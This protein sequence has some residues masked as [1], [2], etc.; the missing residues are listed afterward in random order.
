MIFG[1][2]TVQ[3]RQKTACWA[4]ITRI[5]LCC[6]GFLLSLPSQVRSADFSNAGLLFDEFDLT[7]TLGQRTEALGPFFYSEQK[8]TQRSWGVPPL[9]THTQD[10]A[11]E[12]EEFDLL[13]PLVTYD[14]FG[15]Q[16]RWPVFQLLSVGSGPTQH[17]DTRRRLTLFPFYFQQRSSDPSENYTTILPF[18]GHIKNRLFRD[19]ISF[20]MFPLYVQTRKADVVTDNYLYPLFHL[21]HGEDLRGWQLWPLAGREHKGITTQT[22]GFNDVQ[23]IGGH[24]KFF[25]LWPLFFEQKAGIGTAN[26][27]WMQGSIPAYNLLRS[28]QRDSTTVLWPFFSRID[29]REKQY[30]EWEV[31][32]PFIIIARGQGKTTTR[33]FPLFG[34]AHSAYLESDFYLWPVY[35]FNRVHAAPADRTRTRICFFLYSDITEKNTET[36]GAQHRTDFWPL[37]TYRRDFN[38]NSRLQILAPLEPYLPNN[39]SIERDY[40]P[41]WSVWRSEN[42]PKTGAASQSLLWNLYR[43]ETNP[44]SKKTSLCFG[45]FQSQSDVD[46]TR[47]RLFYIP[48]RK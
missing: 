15:D 39:K 30:R 3:V 42:N 29:D 41:L 23:T 34:R 46:G 1:K 22:N 43:R 26:P 33:V 10:P 48:L 12:S 16:Y 38:G 4:I 37:Y 25:L 44:V 47:R 18:Y 2:I 13:Y 27:Q 8:E 5:F 6:F 21:R 24:D 14:R 36:G 19:E 7:L 17:E 40:S 11:T 35:K 20:V 9:F 28:P 31:P 32:W 45:L